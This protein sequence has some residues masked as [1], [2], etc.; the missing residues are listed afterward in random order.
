LDLEISKLLQA[1]IQNPKQKP[2]SG[3]I[4][5][6]VLIDETKEDIRK[7]I[8]DSIPSLIHRR[9]NQKKNLQIT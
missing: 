2:N 9:S 4:D 7:I 1:I 3:W 5:I 6:S 8:K